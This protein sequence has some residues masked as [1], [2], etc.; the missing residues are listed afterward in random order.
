MS[1]VSAWITENDIA[2]GNISDITPVALYDDL[3]W[4]AMGEAVGESLSAKIAMDRLMEWNRNN[5]PQI[6]DKVLSKKFVWAVKHF[7]N[8]AFPRNLGK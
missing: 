4:Q 2:T 3:V 5:S 1:N 7:D 8:V 6:P